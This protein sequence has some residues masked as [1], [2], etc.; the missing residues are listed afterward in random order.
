[1]GAESVDYHRATV[2][3]RGDDHPGMAIEYYASRGETP[4]VWG[5]SGTA[6][7]GLEGAVS[8]EDY[9]AIFGPGGARDPKTGERLVTTR[10]PGMEVVISAHKSVAELGV[11]GRAE[12]MHAIMD[13][14]RD[15]TLAYLDRVTRRMGGRRGV[16]A[17]GRRRPVGLIYAHTRHATSRPATL[18]RTTMCWWPTWSRCS[19]RQGGWKAADT[20][21]WREHLHAATMAGR[22]AAARVGRRAGLR[23]RGRPGPV[24]AAWDTGGSP[25]SPTRCYGST[26]SGRPRSTPSASAGATAYRAQS[27]GRPGH[28]QDQGARTGEGNL[29]PRR[30]RPSWP[31]SA[32]P[33]RV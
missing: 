19:T 14:E 10:R 9:E 30:G 18:A 6:G 15:A 33:L 11:I 2:L 5:G 21:L 28:P 13:A 4:L 29:W 25:A 20:A 1:M 8:R 27:G 7:L 22:A 26:P 17:R 16:A 12:D 3:G 32:G 23:H 31:P 24:G